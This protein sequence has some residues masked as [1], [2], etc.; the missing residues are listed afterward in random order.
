M[1]TAAPAVTEVLDVLVVGAGFAGLYQL[2]NLRSRG[3]SVK[4]VEAGEGLGGIWHWN[5][6]PGARVDSE[7]PIYQSRAP[8]TYGM[9]SR[10][11]SS[12]PPEVTNCAATSSTST[13]SSI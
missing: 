10:S 5:R 13:R 1:S 12:T 9:N 2:E 7:G 4:V 8:P 11:P 6:Y 3:Y